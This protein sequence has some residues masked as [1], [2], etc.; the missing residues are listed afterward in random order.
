MNSNSH[1]KRVAAKV[2][3]ENGVFD[4]ECLD[5]QEFYHYFLGRKFYV[6]CSTLQFSEDS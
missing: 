1:E 2:Q 6:S 3:K 5:S 4:T